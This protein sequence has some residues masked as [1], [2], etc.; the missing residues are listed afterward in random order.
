MG[1]KIEEDKVEQ[2]V[3]KIDKI[4]NAVATE[5]VQST[6]G[7]C[8]IEL[9]DKY[10]LGKTAEKRLEDLQLICLCYANNCFPC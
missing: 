7:L 4:D 10:K 3:E 6:R 2:T 1:Q 5:L 9:D 8:G